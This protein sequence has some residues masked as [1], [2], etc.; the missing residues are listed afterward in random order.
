[1]SANCPRTTANVSN[2]RETM[3]PTNPVQWGVFN[4]SE[5]PAVYLMFPYKEEVS[6]VAIC[7]F[8]PDRSSVI[9]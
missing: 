6:R 2:H 7:T 1:M 4:E 9:G 8:A 3:Q 5:P